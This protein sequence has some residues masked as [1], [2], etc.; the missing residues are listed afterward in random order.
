[1]FSLEALLSFQD[2]PIPKAKK[3]KGSDRLSL[4]PALETSDVT[5]GH[6][7]PLPLWWILQLTAEGMGWNGMSVCLSCP[8]S[9]QI[10]LSYSTFLMAS[11][12]MFSCQLASVAQ[13]NICFSLL[14][15]GVVS[16]SK[17]MKTRP[18]QIEWSF[19]ETR[20][21]AQLVI[22]NLSCRTCNIY[23]RGICNL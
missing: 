22:K 20:N 8:S 13:A 14:N 21:R 5:A 9:Q 4:S 11:A 7:A 18:L 3:P 19:P 12:R 1:M 23:I 17:T 10:A 16:Y 15:Q 2:D 6:L